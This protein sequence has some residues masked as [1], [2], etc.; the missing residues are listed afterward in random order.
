MKKL[1]LLFLVLIS[2]K[3]SGPKITHIRGITM[4]MPYHVQIARDLTAQEERAVVQII[5]K[6]FEEANQIY[7]HYN[8]HSELSYLPPIQHIHL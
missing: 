7:N 8:P 5:Q 2:C 3:S 6:S 1:V 4:S